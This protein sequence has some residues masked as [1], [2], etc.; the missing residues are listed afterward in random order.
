MF[1][2]SSLR[3]SRGPDEPNKRAA[4]FARK[5]IPDGN[6]HGQKQHSGHALIDRIDGYRLNCKWYVLEI[7]GKS[8]LT[9]HPVVAQQTDG[10]RP[11]AKIGGQETTKNDESL[12]ETAQC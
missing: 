7:L 3:P 12:E 11:L 1:I 6:R 4:R 8:P 5:A 9:M 2:L 10:A